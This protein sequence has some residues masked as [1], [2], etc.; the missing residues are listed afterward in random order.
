MKSGFVAALSIVGLV[1]V[2]LIAVLLLP[3]PESAPGATTGSSDNADMESLAAKSLTAIVNVRVFDGESVLESAN[4]LF[5]D[6]R[7]SEVGRGIGVPDRASVVDG[8]G[9]TLLPGLVDS[10]V[11]AIGTARADAVDFGVTTL[12]DM[13]SMTVNL[14]QVHD[15]RQGLAPTARADVFTA[16]Y[17]A[18]A[19]GGHGTQYGV[20]VPTLSSPAEADDWVAARLEEGSDFIKIVIEDG[21]AFGGSLPTLSRETVEALVESAHQ[22]NTLA[23]AHVST[24]DDAMTAIEAG[25]DGLV[26]LFADRQVDTAFIEAAVESGIFVV[27]TATVMASVYD[28][29]GTEWLRNHEILAGRLG[30][31]QR[32]SLAQSFPG[33]ESRAS[34]WANVKF[35]I[36]A[37]HEAGIPILAG[38]DAPNPGTAQG[39]SIHAELALLVESGLGPVDALRSATSN[40]TRLFGLGDRGCIRSG[41]RADLVLIDGNPLEAIEASARVES[42][43]K[44]GYRVPLEQSES[45]TAQEQTEGSKAS[46]RPAESIDLL[47]DPTRWMAAADDYMGGKSSAAIDW[48]RAADSRALQ[49]RANVEQGFAFPYAGAMWNTTGIPMQPADHS[50]HRRLVLEIDGPGSDYQLMLFSGEAMG[51]QPIRAPLPVGRE[52]VIEFGDL[53]GLDLATLRAIGVFATSPSD[54]RRFTITTARLE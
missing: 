54:E 18:T 37:L 45:S 15:Q 2:L 53:D 16:G 28:G 13:F 44:N 9:K 39:V 6:G 51:A 3:E 41:C 21:S 34:M 23:V 10:H 20:P 33:S 48:I 7:I 42:I 36:G 52:S 47:D 30:A 26:H 38:T 49:V 25:V 22:R 29:P 24:Y 8:R 19:A 5:S 31:M 17:L 1:G 32:Q 12:L 50:S 35:N 14:G 46:P 43:W 40:P 27:P 11:H 4:V